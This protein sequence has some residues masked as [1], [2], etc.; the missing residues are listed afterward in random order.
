MFRR[1]KCEWNREEKLETMIQKERER[2]KVRERER[3]SLA[4]R[5]TMFSDTL[6]QRVFFRM[7]KLYLIRSVLRAKKNLMTVSVA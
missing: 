6:Q 7:R 3:E 1:W 5:H 4:P 2:V